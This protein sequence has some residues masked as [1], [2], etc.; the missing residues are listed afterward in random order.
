MY[1]N[2]NPELNPFINRKIDIYDLKELK[3]YGPDL[4]QIDLYNAELMNHH[5]GKLFST[6]LFQ[7]EIN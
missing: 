7:F 2:Q 1:F 4:K 3:M 6:L 5:L